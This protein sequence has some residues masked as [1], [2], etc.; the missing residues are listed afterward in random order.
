[1]T[2]LDA[3]TPEIPVE[4][5]PSA[6]DVI[7]VTKLYGTG[8]N[9][10]RALDN[11]TVS[12]E[13]SRFTAIMGPSGSGKSTLLHVSAGLDDVTS[14]KIVMGDTDITE[15]RD[16]ELTMLRRSRIGFIFQTFN[17]L[18]TLTA[19]ENI[20]LPL[21]LAGR[22]PDRAWLDEVVSMVGL[23]NRLHHRPGELSGGQQQRVAVA[24]ALVTQ[25]DVVYA[26]E[27]TG[28][29]DSLSGT[30]ILEFLRQ[31]VEEHHQTIVMVTHDAH[32]A[33]YADRVVF[34]SDGRIVDELRNPTQDAVFDRIRKMEA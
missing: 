1:M 10:V 21:S 7:G 15:L 28:N 33:S 18:P 24:R 16:R 3:R 19:M 11:I 17:L 22:K 34:L 8:L 30:A 5:V 4:A 20:T 32:A 25:P 12:F 23:Y 6:L 13:Q 2:N 26:D 14:G 31:A 9:A 29:L 27:P